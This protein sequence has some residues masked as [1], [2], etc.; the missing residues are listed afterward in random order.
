MRHERFSSRLRLLLECN[1]AKRKEGENRFTHDFISLRGNFLVLTCFPPFCT[2]SICSA[3]RL[4]VASIYALY[5][6]Q[7]KTFHRLE[8]VKTKIYSF[9]VVIQSVLRAREN[10]SVNRFQANIFG[11]CE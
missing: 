4:F 11:I 6:S 8:Y 2:E 7:H 1:F 9:L 10:G 3:G 5:R